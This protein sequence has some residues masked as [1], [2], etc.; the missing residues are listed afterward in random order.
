MR[1]IF[2]PNASFTVVGIYRP[3]SSSVM[4]NEHLRNLLKE[5]ERNKE[6]IMAGDPNTNWAEKSVRKKL[7]DTTSQF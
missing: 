6:L 3:P 4:F 1:Q 7:K 5:L 2:Y